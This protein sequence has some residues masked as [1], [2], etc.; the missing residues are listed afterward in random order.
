MSFRRPCGSSVSMI[1]AAHCSLATTAA[2][3]LALASTRSLL[4]ASFRSA[5]LGAL[6]LALTPAAAAIYQTPPVNANAAVIQD[7]MKRVS[8]YVVLH[9]K[10]ED[11]LPKL[12]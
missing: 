12:S 2:E 11:T 7:F 10:R 1:S 3:G 5:I 4:R 9:K 6:L 8:D